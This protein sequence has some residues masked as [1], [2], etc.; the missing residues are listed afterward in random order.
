MKCE[1]KPVAPPCDVDS[2]T[3]STFLMCGMF[4][5]VAMVARRLFRQPLAIAALRLGELALLAASVVPTINQSVRTDGVVHQG[6]AALRCVRCTGCP[7]KWAH[8]C[9]M[10]DAFALRC[11][12]QVYDNSRCLRC[13][14]PNT[15][16]WSRHS[17][18]MEPI[19]RS[20]YPF[21]QGD[22]EKSDGRG[23]PSDLTRRQLIYH[24]RHRDHGSENGDLLPTTGLG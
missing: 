1:L 18:R 14:S 5:C 19:R 8:P 20:A 24:S 21:C 2:G 9:L 12:T 4:C 16:T 23:I 17:R 13:R 10:K 3:R 15:M 11:S 7:F 6:R 22:A